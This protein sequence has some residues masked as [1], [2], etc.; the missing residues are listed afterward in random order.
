MWLNYPFLSIGRIIGGEGEF[1]LPP[2]AL[3][4]CG[5]IMSNGYTVASLALT[6]KNILMA[7][8][9]INDLTTYQHFI[10]QQSNVAL[11]IKNGLICNLSSDKNTS[12]YGCKMISDFDLYQ[13]MAGNTKFNEFL[14]SINVATTSEFAERLRRNRALVRKFVKSIYE[15][16]INLMDFLDAPDQNAT[17]IIKKRKPRENI[18]KEQLKAAVDVS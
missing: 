9:I 1:L 8:N 15:T 3:N 11:A 14:A 12:L 7:H 18:T 13:N 17:K 6:L 5:Q 16:V 10:V 4:V 2:E